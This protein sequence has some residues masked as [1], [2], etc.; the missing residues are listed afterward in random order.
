[1]QRKSSQPRLMKCCT[2]MHKENV[3]KQ[4]CMLHCA[5]NSA[6]ENFIYFVSLTALTLFRKINI[7]NTNYAP[8]YSVH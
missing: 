4:Y 3:L 6:N 5:F 1:M 7:I 8:A 2:C